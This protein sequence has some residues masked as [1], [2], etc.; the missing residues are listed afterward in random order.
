MRTP[1]RW[2]ARGN[3]F[4][5]TFDGAGHEISGLYVSEGSGVALFG[6]LGSAGG[7]KD[8]TVSGTVHGGHFVGGV[9]AICSGTMEGVT[10]KVV[11]SATGNSVGGVAA[12]GVGT[13]T[14]TD[15]HNRAF[16]SNSS[17]TRSSGKV[18]G[19]IGRVDTG[20]SATITECSN[21]APITGYQYV[22]GIIGGQFGP[23]DVSYCCNTGDL[24]GVSFGKVYL[25]GISGTLQDGSISY[26]YNTG[27]LYDQHWAAG[28]VRAIGGIAGCEEN[29]TAGTAIS[30]C[31]TTGS[32]FIYTGNM[33]YGTNWIYMLGN[34][35]GGN[36]S[37]AAN[38]MTYENC[39][40]L[41]N[42][43]AQAD[44]SHADYK[45]W[46]DL[47]KADHLIWDTSY[48]TAKTGEEMKEPAFLDGFSAPGYFIED[49]NNI[50][51]GYPVL[52]WQSDQTPPEEPQYS[53]TTETFGSG[54]A[55]VALSTSTAAAGTTV[56]VTVS[57]LQA[58]KQVRSVTVTDTAGSSVSVT[59]EN[60]N[61]TYT[62]TMPARNVTVQVIIE[63]KVTEGTAYN[64][65]V[66]TGLDAIWTVAVDSTYKTGAQVTE[67]ASVFFTV[68]KDEAA[69][70]TSFEG[71]TI[72]T[73]S[74]E[75]PFTELLYTTDSDGSGVRGVYLFTM[76]AGDVNVTLTIDYATI[77]V[78]RQTGEDGTPVLLGSYT[79]DEMLNLAAPGPVYYSGYYSEKEPFIGKAEQAV[80]LTALLTDAG[81]S[82][83]EGD[84]LDVAA[85]DGMNLLFTYDKL[86]GSQRYYYPNLISGATGEEKAA[87]ATP[88]D[89]LLVIK[90]YMARAA[91]GSVDSF[92]CDT[93]DAYRFVFGQTETEFNNG[94]PAVEYKAVDKMPKY[95]SKITVIEPAS[96]TYSV[97]V[98]RAVTG[99]SL[100]L[101]PA[102]GNAGDTITVTVTPDSGKQLVAGSLKYTADG[103]TSYTEIIAA[104]G[105]YS[106][107]MP[108]ADVT[109]TAQFE[110]ETAGA[111]V[112]DG[113]TI[114]TA[115]YTGA[116]PG[117]TSYIITTPAQLAGLAAIVN[118]TAPGIAQDNFAGK[119][120]TLANDIR[121]DSSNTKYTS[122]SGRF[123]TASFAMEATWYEIHAD[124]N[125]WTPIGS[126]VA[127][128][129]SAFSAANY[130]RG[131][132]DGAGHTVSGLY[133]DL[134]LT[135]QGLFGCVGQGGLLKN[136]SVEGCV[137]GKFV[138]GGIA[139][140]LNSGTVQNCVNKAVIYADGGQKAG[141]GLEN[142]PNKIGAVGGIVGS[143]TGTSADPAVITG[144]K[145]YGPVTCTNT[146]QGGR[147]GGIAGIVDKAT[148][149]GTI[150]NCVN[151]G[152]VDGYQYSGGIA[153]MINSVNVPIINCG[154]TALVSGHS[155]GH[156][157]VGGIV[158]TTPGPVTN[159]FNTGNYRSAIDGNAG[160]L[161]SN[162]GGIAGNNG[163]S[164]AGFIKNCYNTGTFVMD[165]NTTTG[166]TVGIIC[167]VTQ[168]SG[169]LVNCYFLDTALGSINRNDIN[170]NYLSINQAR[171]DAQMKA[172]PFLEELNGDGRA[173]VAD[174]DNIN[175]GY[176]IPRAWTTSIT[177]E[178]YT[179]T[180]D[181]AITGGTVT[182]DPASGSA[183]DTITVTVTPDHGKQL[184]A[185][186][187]KYTTDGS[188]YT[189]IT[190]TAGVYS[191][192]LPAADVTV[193]AQF[194]DIS[195][196]PK[197][198]VTAVEDGSVYV[199]GE[200]GGI[201]TMTVKGGIIGLKYFGTLITPVIGHEGKEAVAFV[202]LRSGLQ[203]SINVTRAD[204]DLMDEAQAGFNV[205][206]GDIVRVYIVDDLTNDP[207]SNPIML[208]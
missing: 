82:F 17:N 7:I 153:G 202:H 35:S 85:V 79:R 76:P 95:V 51:E 136:F 102:G 63:N 42:R 188:D 94:V 190:A 115:W 27:D 30:N 78:Y 112:W 21:T 71:V 201:S 144:C 3:I 90:G 19:I 77:S 13:V 38:T 104:G 149:F 75:V 178:T 133:T 181:N 116:E 10:N 66:P 156:C 31:Y 46:A 154:N 70:M 163:A 164:N 40:Y 194:E 60:P 56:T 91:E 118:G 143:M 83:T 125:I 157:C 18:G 150:A 151:F 105:V 134:D 44:P 132:F 34:I 197:Y 184:V 25:G 122:D 187:L 108:A 12:E 26:C 80:T 50:N 204:F 8:L 179:V 207:G 173:F 199:V 196:A 33:I 159:C 41:E 168:R 135:V 32:I 185:G 191:F 103:G 37:T 139:A 192:V 166:S 106:F 62:F 123:G 113:A 146:N 92:T 68:S 54:S 109:V 58:G 73:A 98:D 9:A 99:G 169:D 130:F 72:T 148:D 177:P 81:V 64:L 162:Y 107:V 24:T 160:N 193:T 140:Y 86:Y 142:G 180:V 174:A 20:S 127:T 155:S 129:N 182:V 74:G 23:V 15:C 200:T 131:V 147:T 170:R 126:G 4:N 52:Y 1:P 48:I 121:L 47:Y 55:D 2:T 172:A 206:A 53:I 145:N 28:H 57:D 205:Q 39:Y 138:V 65:T 36:S 152:A 61:T 141:S 67:G 101:S 96:G 165:G 183:G 167:G 43:I 208:Q 203:L 198:T 117:T 114:D 110:D 189:A 29:H 59:T 195:Q 14:I 88:V 69:R 111:P 11:V 5:G 119:S 124:A 49:R 89:M 6:Y 93:L 161:A 171:T 16:V 128:G 45:F 97:T 100:G 175:S 158:A 137:S 87:G 120:V 186:S 176:P 22:G 84:T